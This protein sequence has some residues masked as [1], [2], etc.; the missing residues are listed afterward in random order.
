MAGRTLSLYEPVK[1]YRDVFRQYHICGFFADIPAYNS[2]GLDGAD[3]IYTLRKE[4]KLVGVKVAVR[5]ARR[6]GYEVVGYPEIENKQHWADRSSD[7]YEQ[8]RINVAPMDNVRTE[9]KGTYLV[10]RATFEVMK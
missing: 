7:A 9:P 10:W 3:I 1:Q 5:M 4:K 2:V 8:R 6:L